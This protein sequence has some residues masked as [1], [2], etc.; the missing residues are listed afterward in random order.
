[1]RIT[2]RAWTFPLQ[3]AARAF[4]WADIQT[5]NE[6]GEGR[7]RVG[8]ALWAASGGRGEGGEGRREGRERGREGGREGREGGRGG[9]EHMV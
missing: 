5:E 2:F 8:L 6:E 7:D 3:Q 4:S 9:R 1:M